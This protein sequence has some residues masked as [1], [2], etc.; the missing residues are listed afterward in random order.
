MLLQ[1]LR[2]DRPYGTESWASI[3]EAPYSKVLKMTQK[4]VYG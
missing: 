2:G 3:V 4:D 1:T